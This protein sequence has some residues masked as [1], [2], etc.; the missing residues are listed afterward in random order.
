MLTADSTMASLV[1]RTNVMRLAKLYAA[2][3]VYRVFY[4]RKVKDLGGSTILVTG[5]LMDS[6]DKCSDSF[7]T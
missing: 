6:S 1:T 4:P 2:Y 7:F 5:K 3:K